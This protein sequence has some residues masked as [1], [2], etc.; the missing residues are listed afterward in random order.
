MSLRGGGPV[1]S[2]IPLTEQAKEKLEKWFLENVED[3]FPTDR[4]KMDLGQTC[5]MTQQNVNNWFGNKRM[6]IKRKLLNLPA[7]TD[8]DGVADAANISDKVLSPRAKWKAVVVSRLRTKA[9]RE[10]ILSAMGRAR[11]YGEPHDV[12]PELRSR[13]QSD[14][15]LGYQ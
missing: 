6:R 15:P 10:V 4:E 7:G 2:R 5:G 11:A 12:H 13:E 8:E 9:G 14:G 1:Q 3:P